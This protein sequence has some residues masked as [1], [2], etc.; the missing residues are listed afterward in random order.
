VLDK[1]LY[2]DK[3]IIL[4]DKPHP[5]KEPG[6]NDFKRRYIKLFNNGQF[7]N[8]PHGSIEECYPD[9][10]KKTSDQVSSMTSEQKVKLAKT[11]GADITKEDFESQMAHVYESLKQCWD[12][13][14]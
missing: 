6:F 12:K 5:S 14:Y 7:F 2:N 10:W 3:L 13:C 8:L 1:S 4:C 9:P 11:V